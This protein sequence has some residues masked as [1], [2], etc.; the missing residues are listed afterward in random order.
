MKKNRR[1]RMVA[2][3]ACLLALLLL[4]PMILMIVSNLPAAGAAS[5]TSIRQ[6]IDQLKNKNKDLESQKANLKN[7]LKS[8]QADKNEAISKKN[9][10]EQQ[11]NVLQDS[12]QNL[13]DQIAQYDLLIAEKEREVEENQAEEERQFKRFCKQVRIM[14]EEGTV[15]YWSILFSADSFTDLLDRVSLV[16]DIADYN[17]KVCDE[18][19]AARLAL[20]EARAELESAQA[21]AQEAKTEQ[22]SARSELQSQE[23][24]VK[25]LINEISADE[26]KAKAAI[27]DLNAAA[28]AMDAEIAKKEKELEAA[29]AEE[30][31]RAEQNGTQSKYAFD[32]GTGF[33]W[34][35]PSNR[36]TIT[37]FFGYRN[38]PFTGKSSNHYGTDISAPQGTEIYTAHGGIVLTSTY[39]SSYGNYVVISRGDGTNT[40]YAHMTK[41]AVEVGQTVAQGQ[42][43][44]Y[45]GSTG[46]S[47]APH[48]H[49]EVRVN[50]VRGDILK[51]YPGLNW[52]NHTGY[53]YK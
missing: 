36:V 27:E 47:T 12:I 30:R 17:Q 18:L 41:R 22:E 35:L 42:V 38:D 29:I 15:S 20:Q 24:E 44:G 49:F 31:R 26:A 37:S 52:I 51:Y 16:N 25:T 4:L 1:Q 43:I 5:S 2:L 50:G 53:E 32:P 3:L 9:V 19:E 23:S 28:D 14:E 39:N 21:E 7:Q 33:Y 34:P 8:I 45:V 11:I 10:L 48:L 6:S 13:N 46:R 40:L